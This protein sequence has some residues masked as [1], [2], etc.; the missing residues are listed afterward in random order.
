MKRPTEP[1]NPYSKEAVGRRLLVFREGLRL[2]QA[3]MA[4]ALGSTSSGGQMIYNYETGKRML[5]P[6]K[7]AIL[8][9]KWGLDVAWVYQGRR[10]LVDLDLRLTEIIAQGERI[11]RDRERS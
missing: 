5:P 3:E 7:A 2:S 10:T 9:Q 6:E 8:T 11:V 1:F 4:D